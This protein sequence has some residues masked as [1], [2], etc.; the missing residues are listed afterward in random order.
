MSDLYRRIAILEAVLREIAV[1]PCIDSEGNKQI[2]LK[3][4]EASDFWKP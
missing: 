4:L 1:D 3:A 2:A